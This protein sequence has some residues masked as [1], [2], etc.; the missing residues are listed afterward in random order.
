[1]SLQDTSFL[2]QFLYLF[3][4]NSTAIFIMCA[5]MGVSLMTYNVNNNLLEEKEKFKS[6]ILKRSW[7]LFAIGLLLYNWWAGDILHFY[8]G[9]M[10]I[11]AFML[12]V[13]KRYLLIGAVST[14]LI[15]HILL[16]I[17]PIFTS[18]DLTTFKYAD[19]WTIKGFLRNTFYNGWNSIFPWIAYFLL[20]MWLGRLNWR[21]KKVKKTVFLIGLTLFLLFERLR[22]YAL[23]KQ[24]KRNILDYIM[25]D[26]FPPYLPFMIITASFGLLVITICIW[27]GDKFSHNTPLQWLAET[28]KMTLTHYVVHLTIGM[29]TFQSLTGKKY[30]GFLQSGMPS[31]PAHIFAF[32]SLFFLVSVAF[33]VLWS[34]KFRRGPLENLM[35]KFSG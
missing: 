7:F 26:Y 29:I 12:F 18:W 27:L 14:I 24:F 16:F 9:Y 15:F 8:G 25:Y 34:R 35:R 23:Y 19:F 2:G 3:T 13:Q 10:H 28:G 4:G 30:T 17:I 22:Q 20:G 5:G 6:I 1:M 31:S 11:A 21:N 33:S 32:S